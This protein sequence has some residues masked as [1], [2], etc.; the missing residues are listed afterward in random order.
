MDARVW[1]EGDVQDAQY[2]VEDSTF[3]DGVLFTLLEWRNPLAYLDQLVSPYDPNGTVI[4]FHRG[5]V[6]VRVSRRNRA[7][8]ARSRP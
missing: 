4:H 6:P 3:K 5:R 1:F 7:V 2:V 8:S